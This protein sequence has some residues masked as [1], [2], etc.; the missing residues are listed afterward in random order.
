MQ[1]APHIGISRTRAGIHTRHASITH[2]RENHG[3]HGDQNRRDHMSLAGVAENSICRHGRGGLDDDDAVKDQVPKR[4]R[5][6]KPG[7][8]DRGRRGSVFHESGY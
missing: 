4:E 8:G 3:D 7:R 5:A 2:G 1:F 6:A